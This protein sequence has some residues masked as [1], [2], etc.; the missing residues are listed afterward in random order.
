VTAR[1]LRITRAAI[2]GRSLD[3][4]PYISPR[5]ARPPASIVPSLPGSGHVG[6][7]ASALTRG[8]LIHCGCLTPSVSPELVPASS[9][10]QAD[11]G[12]AECAI[13]LR[14]IA[15]VDAAA[16][17]TRGCCDRT[18]TVSCPAFRPSLHV[19]CH[20]IRAHRRR[21]AARPPRV[22]TDPAEASRC[23]GVWALTIHGEVPRRDRIDQNKF[24]IPHRSTHRVDGGCRRRCVRIPRHVSGR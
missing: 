9:R 14:T 18:V 10:G 13:C 12:S 4:S 19:R 5:Q 17:S 16:P 2:L 20:N 22:L 8:A 21:R 3:M 15:Y 7:A 23:S 11:F 6:L 1:R 24:A